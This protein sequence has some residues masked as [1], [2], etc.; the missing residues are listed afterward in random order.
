MVKLLSLKSDKEKLLCLPSI[1]LFVSVMMRLCS[2]RLINNTQI[3]LQKDMVVKKVC[4]KT[5]YTLEE[6]VWYIWFI[7]KYIR[8]F[9]ILPH[10]TYAA[11]TYICI[12]C[13]YMSILATECVV[14]WFW[15]LPTGKKQQKI[16]NPK[17]K[18]PTHC[19]HLLMTYHNNKHAN[20]HMRTYPLKATAAKYWVLIP[21]QAKQMQH[22]FHF[23]SKK[24]LKKKN[25]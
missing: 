13:I 10:V 25:K 12:Y 20:K 6:W 16:T 18:F 22:S 14:V 15:T 1:E 24:Y 5:A 23:L 19:M 4:L 17:K 8:V 7:C 3:Q 2:I 21:P 11:N 9:K